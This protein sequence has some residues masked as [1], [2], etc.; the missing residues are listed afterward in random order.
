MES[1]RLLGL[2]TE[3]ETIKNK[4]MLLKIITINKRYD[5]FLK[6]IDGLNSILDKPNKRAR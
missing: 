2:K 6:S 3:Q 1:G 4:K 5:L